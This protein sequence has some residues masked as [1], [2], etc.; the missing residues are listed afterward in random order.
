MEEEEEEKH[1]RPR[2]ANKDAKMFG[3]G[4]TNPCELGAA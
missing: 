4:T 3:G 1:V 2:L